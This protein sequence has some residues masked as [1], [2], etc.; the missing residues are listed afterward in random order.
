LEQTKIAQVKESDLQLTGS[1]TDKLT[2]SD[3]F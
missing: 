2:L 1:T 3:L